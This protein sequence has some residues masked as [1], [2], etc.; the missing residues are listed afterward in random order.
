MIPRNPNRGDKF[1]N[2]AYFGISYNL[3]PELRQPAWEEELQKLGLVWR[4]EKERYLWHD[5]SE[6][7]AIVAVRSFDGKIDYPW[8]PASK[9]FNAW[10]ANVPA[11]LG[12]E[13]AFQGERKSELDYFEVKSAS[14]AIAVLKRLKDDQELRRAIVAN[15]QVRAEEIKP[16]NIAKRW[17]NFLTEVCVP[18]YYKW[19]EAS[20]WERQRFF[21]SRQAA[22]KIVNIQKKLMRKFQS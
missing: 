21:L 10:N 4:R 5:Y 18:A 2:V 7:D 9:L 12:V 8:K 20:A 19:R 3:A 22:L 14:E 15:C 6:V 17:S 1:K 11:I 16:E 13:S